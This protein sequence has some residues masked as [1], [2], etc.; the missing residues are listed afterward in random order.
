MCLEKFKYDVFKVIW[1]NT[2]ACDLLCYV[3]VI[4]DQKIVVKVFLPHHF[5]M[6]QVQLSF[7]CCSSFLRFKYQLKGEL[8]VAHNSHI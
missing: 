6:S 8:V 3:L 4:Y 7:E 5:T 1:K 2:Y